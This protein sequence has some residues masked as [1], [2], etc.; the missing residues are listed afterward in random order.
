[1][2]AI[3]HKELVVAKKTRERKCGGSE[4]GSNGWKQRGIDHRKRGGVAQQNFDTLLKRRRPG[5]IFIGAPFS[6]VK[7]IGLAHVLETF[8]LDLVVVLASHPLK[9][10]THVY[11]PSLKTNVAPVRSGEAEP[12]EACQKQQWNQRAS[13]GL[14]YSAGLREC[15]LL[16]RRRQKARCCRT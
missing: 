12:A 14:V 16:R 4:I 15:R 3:E 1:M 11:P 13:A 10:S 5:D 8:N 9:I 2:V 7:P 6:L